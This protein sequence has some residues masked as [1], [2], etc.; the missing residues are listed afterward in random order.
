MGISSFVAGLGLLMF[1]YVNALVN[2]FI[3]LVQNE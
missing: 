1:P 3:F 2:N